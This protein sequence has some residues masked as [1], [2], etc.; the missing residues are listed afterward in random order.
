MSD[1]E[2]RIT[3]LEIRYTY[4]EEM[5]QT[6]SEVIRDQQV[7]ID[8]LKKEISRLAELQE[9]DNEDAPPPHY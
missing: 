8:G 7:V 5:L 1:F 9:A 2:E 4:S 6:L 3:Q